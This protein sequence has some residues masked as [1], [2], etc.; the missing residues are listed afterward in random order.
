MARSDDYK[1]FYEQLKPIEHQKR[2]LNSDE[3]YN[4]TKI[5]VEKYFNEEKI[6]LLDIGCGD[7]KYAWYFQN[8]G[9][10]VQGIDKFEPQVRRA[11]H[12]IDALV[13]DAVSLPFADNSFDLCTM[14]MV[15]H[16]LNHE[17]RVRAFQE[18]HRVLKPGGLFV[19]K[20]CSHKDLGYRFTSRFFDEIREND[21]KR[22]PDTKQLEAELN[23]FKRI[24][25][26]PVS[27]SYTYAKDELMDIYCTRQSSNMW[28]L[29]DEALSRGIK[30]FD[31]TYKDQKITKET[32]NT[33]FTYAR[34]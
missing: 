11:R 16:L 3:D 2:G 5:I 23:L 12:W 18:V 28:L 31:D 9:Y 33:F 24:K 1:D 25:I 13:A 21:R 8:Q 22:Y 10:I 26:Q 17:E 30:L 27:V 29:D 14:I 32:H 6:R 19:I 15:I 4:N 7:G 34:E 20:T